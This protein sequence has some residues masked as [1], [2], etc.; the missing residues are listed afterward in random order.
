MKN[1]LA[2]ILIVSV[3]FL[4]GCENR[5]SAEVASYVRQLAAATNENEEARLTE[6]IRMNS[7]GAEVRIYFM[8]GRGQV[9]EEAAYYRLLEEKPDIQPQLLFIVGSPVEAVAS[10]TFLN[11]ETAKY[12]LLPY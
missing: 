8:D 10:R 5:K 6:L 4:S 11:R 3:A 9:I 1:A 12:L 7:K 2:A